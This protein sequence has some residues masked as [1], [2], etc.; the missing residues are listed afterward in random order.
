MRNRDAPVVTIRRLA[1]YLRVLNDVNSTGERYVS[2]QELGERAGVTSAQVRKDLSM[3]GEFGKQGV[4]Y[5]SAYLRDEIARILHADRTINYAVIGAG[6]LGMALGRYTQR[7]RQLDSDYPF[8]LV[9]IFD[10]DEAKIG[11]MVGAVSVSH[12][13]S[14]AERVRE[15]KFNMALLTVPPEAAQPLVDMAAKAGLKAILNFVPVRLNVPQGVRVHSA[16]VSL[17]L[18]GLA[19]F[20]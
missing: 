6:E 7:R 3:F 4:G 19:Y 11:R 17:E 12:I 13:D 10:I 5:Q 18:H 8:K 15:D 16:D 14:L 9:A 2:S 20:L 1:V